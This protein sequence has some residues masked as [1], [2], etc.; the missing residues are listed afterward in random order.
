MALDSSVVWEVRTTGNDDNGG[1]YD[2]DD[3]GTDYSQQ[4]AAQLTLSDLVC[5]IASTTLTSV[6]GGFTVEM[7]DNIIQIKSGT[8]FVVG[9]YQIATYVDTNEVTIDRT[10]SDGSDAT[11]GTGS[12]GG[13]LATPGMAGKALVDH[14]VSGMYIY[15]KSGTYTLSTGSVNVSGGPLHLANDVGVIT[16]GYGIS[17]GDLGA[18]PVLDAGAQSSLTL[19]S[20][21]EAGRTPSQTFLNL[22]ADGNSQAS[23]IGFASLGSGDQSNR[24]SIRCKATDCVTGFSDTNSRDSIASGCTTGFSLEACASANAARCYAVDCATGFFR[25]DACECLANGGAVGFTTHRGD[26]QYT[27]C[28]AYNC[29]GN[30]F[31]ATDVMGIWEACLA[32]ECGGFGF[33]TNGRDGIVLLDCAGYSNS[34]GRVDG[35]PYMDIGAI[36]L[37]ADPFDTAGSDFQP[38]DAATGGALLRGVAFPIGGLPDNTDIGAVQHSDPAGGGGGGSNCIIGG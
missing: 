2:S 29:S 23:V 10:A 17:R 14:G 26:G 13:A 32:S 34:G 16:E 31:D 30:G 38:N 25:A 20:F 19:F 9:F 18:K 15:I 36:N 4:A 12:V 22:E 35:S 28:T 21:L 37:S 5:D 6:T 7:I 8:N 27:R 1:G 3:N 24:Q 33:D 11:S